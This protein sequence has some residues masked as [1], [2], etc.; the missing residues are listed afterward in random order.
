MLVATVQCQINI[1]VQS[2]VAHTQSQKYT[3]ETI[4]YDI[5]NIVNSNILHISLELQ[6]AAYMF[7][8][9]FKFA[10]NFQTS[11]HEISACFMSFGLSTKL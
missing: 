10:L 6:V 4:E 2:T 8:S 11:R 7:L 5:E 3:C 1:H 9:P